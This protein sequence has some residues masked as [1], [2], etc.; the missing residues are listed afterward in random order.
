MFLVKLKKTFFPIFILTIL[1]SACSNETKLAVKLTGNEQKID[2]QYFDKDFWKLD[3]AH[4][5]SD[6]KDLASRY[7]DFFKNNTV[8]ENDWLERYRDTEIHHFSDSLIRLFQDDIS[9]SE[10]ITTAFQRY[11]Y[12]FEK[13]RIPQVVLWFSNFE[14]QSPILCS[15]NTIFIAGEHFLGKKHPLY[16]GAPSYIQFE[17]DKKFLSSQAFQ[18]WAI[19]F[20]QTDEKDPS[21]LSKIIFEGKK[22]YFA[23]QLLQ[24]VEDHRI[25]AYSPEDI[26]WAQQNEGMIWQYYI[27][28]DYLFSNN[29][30]L[31]QRFIDPSPFSKFYLGND[32]DTPGRVGTWIGWQLIR[33]YMK[34]NPDVSLSS[35][36]MDKDAK[37]ILRKSKYK[38][39]I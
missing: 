29:P 12:F 19:N 28:Q 34:N 16:A 8:S 37:K 13:K 18:E 7:P 21:F 11:Q 17:K 25:I 30:K 31:S 22:L 26:E 5:S 15:Q 36:L 6:L 33:S 39:K 4:F 14:M 32:N 2:I 10:E 27:N 3:S 1:F 20:I 35:M 23:E 9:L 38:P 24:H